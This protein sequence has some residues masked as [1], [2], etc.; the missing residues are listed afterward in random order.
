MNTVTH[1]TK[2]STAALLDRSFLI[3]KIDNSPSVRST[4]TLT[5]RAA[6]ILDALSE[7][8]NISPREVFDLALKGDFPAKASE[9]MKGA[10]KEKRSVKKTLVL[11]GRALERMEKIVKE[12]GK[13]RDE[14]ACEVINAVF[15]SYNA[16]IIEARM[17]TDEIRNALFKMDAKPVG[18]YL[19]KSGKIPEKYKDDMFIEKVLE[20]ARHYMESLGDNLDIYEFYFPE[21][22]QEMFTIA[23]SLDPIKL[24]EDEK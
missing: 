22:I 13:K 5:P 24:K 19:R 23:W 1:K 9:V 8:V 21:E 20:A 6:K 18:E 15:D 7:Q 11:S 16:Q 3:T 10:E 2:K 12:T 14:I 17:L 4:F